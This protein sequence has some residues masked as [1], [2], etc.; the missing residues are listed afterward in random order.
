MTKYCLSAVVL[1]ISFTVVIQQ[2]GKLHWIECR[3]KS[4]FMQ[5]TINRICKI[6]WFQLSWP[7]I[8]S[9]EKCVTKYRLICSIFS[10]C[11]TVLLQKRKTYVRFTEPKV[12]V[13][14]I[15]EQPMDCVFEIAWF[16]S[17]LNFHF[18]TWIANVTKYYL[19]C[20][21]FVIF[22][23]RGELSWNWGGIVYGEFSSYQKLLSVSHKKKH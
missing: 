13:Y 15:D 20:T 12:I 6:K 7:F 8:F 22:F 10:I 5:S 19:I 3:M 11:F 18:L 1:S 14:A 9:Q 21:G 16:R 23:F 2:T 4:S 17:N